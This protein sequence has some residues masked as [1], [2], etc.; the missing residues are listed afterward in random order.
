MIFAIR[1]A[2]KMGKQMKNLFMFY[3]NSDHLSKTQK[4]VV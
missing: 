4:K 2:Q 1:K 3:A